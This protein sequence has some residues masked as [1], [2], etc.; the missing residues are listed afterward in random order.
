MR[1]IKPT[2]RKMSRIIFYAEQKACSLC[3][4]INGKNIAKKFYQWKTRTR[5]ISHD[6]RYTRYV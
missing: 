3:T 6:L 4:S 1:E 5:N 2:N